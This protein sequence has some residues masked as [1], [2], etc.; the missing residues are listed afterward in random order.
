MIASIGDYWDEKT[1]SE[2]VTLVREYEDLFPWSFTKMKG[3]KGE[4]GEMKIALKPHA[5]PINKRPYRLNPRVKQT[6]KAEIEKIFTT[7]LIFPVEQSDWISPIVI[8]DKKTVR[9]Q[10]QL[11]TAVTF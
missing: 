10:G 8:Q 11:K 3:I 7:G 9:F 6:V 4:V 1:I 5:K 2:V